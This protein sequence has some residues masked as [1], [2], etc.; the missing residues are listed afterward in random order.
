MKMGKGR[1]SFNSPVASGRP[2]ST[3][4]N[5][6]RYPLEAAVRPESEACSM[7][8]LRMA[9][10]MAVWASFHVGGDGPAS[11]GTK[12]SFNYGGG[13]KVALI[14]PAVSTWRSRK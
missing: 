13:L 2:V 6:L 5:V 4:G 14:E 8:N 1:I 10:P 3:F 11:F 7:T 9:A 12:F